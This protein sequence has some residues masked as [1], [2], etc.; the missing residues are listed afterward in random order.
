MGRLFYFQLMT[1]SAV[2]LFPPNVKTFLEKP[3]RHF[4]FQ[5]YHSWQNGESANNRKQVREEK[6]KWAKKTTEKNGP[7]KFALFERNHNGNIQCRRFFPPEKNETSLLFRSAFYSVFSPFYNKDIHLLTQALM[8][9][10]VL[11]T[12]FLFFLPFAVVVFSF[13]FLFCRCCYY[14]CYDYH[15][16]Y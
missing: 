4:P 6:G 9:A 11:L 10:S 12:F 5:T 13:P 15:H 14:Y 16:Y 2:F 1:S 3:S 8:L 7:C